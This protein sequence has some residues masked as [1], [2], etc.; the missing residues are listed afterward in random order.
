MKVFGH[1]PRWSHLVA[2]G[3]IL[4]TTAVGVATGLV[5][6][7]DATDR[8]R[9]D[10]FYEFAW[11]ANVAAGHGPS[12]SDG[13]TTSG[14]QLLWSLLL[15]PV[16]WVGGANALPA[17]A[18]WIGAILHAATAFTWWSATRD[19]VTALVAA[20]CWLGNPLLLRECQNGQETALACL[21][22]SLLWQRR[23]AGERPFTL[24]AVCAVLARSELLGVV[25]ALSAWR[26]GL[27][28]RSL[29]AP[30]FAFGVQAAS[31]LALGGGVLPDSAL[32]MAWLWHANHAALGAAAGG[33]STA[34]WYLRPVL[35]GGPYALASAMGFGAAVFLVVRPLWPSRWR[36]LPVFAVAAAALLGARDVATPLWVAV[37]LLLLP[38]AR[39]RVWWAAWRRGLAPLVIGLVAVVALHWAVRWYPRDYYAAPLVVAACAA[40]VRIGRWPPAV[41]LFAIAHG[42]A[43]WDLSP[44]PLAGQREMEMAGRFLREVLPVDERV[45]CFNSGLVTFF[46]DVTAPNGQRR[47]VVNLDGVVDARA[48]AALRQRQLGA[49][50]DAERVRFV[51]DNPVQFATDQRLP[52]ACGHWIAP[53]F[54][55]ARDLVEVARFD[56]PELGAGRPAT[57]SMRLYWRRGRGGAPE[58]IGA[59]RDLGAA[60]GGRY[61]LWPARAGEVLEGED[62]GGARVTVVAADTATVFVVLVPGSALGTGRLF[63]RGAAQPVLTLP[64]L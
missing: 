19:R 22:V 1:G 35:L 61:V 44:E 17:V 43:R 54:D 20:A 3:V 58:T 8:L 29:R 49:W 6:H 30:G 42:A 51:L 11:A 12:V 50:L 18:P 33:A 41:L 53:D 24:L 46:A 40:L 64:K 10:A 52:H 28:W 59:P 39:V 2:L 13:I 45:G 63:V 55:P 48:L 56:V 47:A 57:D 25:V 27:R 36:L 9:D 4:V 7:P 14:V 31:C 21:L 26:H 62:L 16:V 5:L 37:L 60:P 34:W 32:P 15:V 23:R 38:A